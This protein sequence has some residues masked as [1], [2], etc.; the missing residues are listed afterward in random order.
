MLHEMNVDEPFADRSIFEG[1]RMGLESAPM[2]GVG[3]LLMGE[4]FVQV[5]HMGLLDSGPPG[6]RAPY[7]MGDRRRGWKPRPL[8]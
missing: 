6:A 3:P 1:G 8:K 4:E 7:P 5:A 2:F